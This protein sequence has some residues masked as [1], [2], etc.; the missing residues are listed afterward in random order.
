MQ[1]KPEKQ[2]VWPELGLLQNK[3]PPK[4]NFR[5][6]SLHCLCTETIRGAISSPR[7]YFVWSFRSCIETLAFYHKCKWT[8]DTNIYFQVG[9]LLRFYMEKILLKSSSSSLKKGK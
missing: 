2:S 6:N 1:F 7:I 3:Q 8:L 9:K 4:L 5:R